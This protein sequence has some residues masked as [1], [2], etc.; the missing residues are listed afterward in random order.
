MHFLWIAPTWLH[1]GPELPAVFHSSLLGRRLGDDRSSVNTQDTFSLLRLASSVLVQWRG[2][3]L[4]QGT[5]LQGQAALDVSICLR[6]LFICLSGRHSAGHPLTFGGGSTRL[7]LKISQWSCH[8]FH[9]RQ[10]IWARAVMGLW[11]SN[12]VLE[13]SHVKLAGTSWVTQ[14]IPTADG[15]CFSRVAGW[16]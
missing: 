3:A 12:S 2:V 7:S 11:Q 6:C 13:L 1:Q 8:P 5:G 10:I 16:C 15:G 4:G 14:T 9:G